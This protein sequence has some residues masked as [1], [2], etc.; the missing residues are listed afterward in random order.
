MVIACIAI[1]RTASAQIPVIEP[2]DSLGPGFVWFWS[3]IQDG[4]IVSRSESAGLRVIERT[5]SDNWVQTASLGT[6]EETGVVRAAVYGNT[7]IAMSVG[8]PEGCNLYVFARRQGAWQQVQKLPF[9]GLELA[10]GARLAALASSQSR[11][12]HV[13]RKQSDGTLE[14]EANLT[15]EEFGIEPPVAIAH[16]T[17]LV[18]TP[19]AND[20][21][22]AVQVFEEVG[23]DWVRRTTLTPSDPDAQSFGSRIQTLGNIA[24]IQAG[25]GDAF[26]FERVGR[27]WHEQTHLSGGGLFFLVDR[28]RVV[29]QLTSNGNVTRYLARLGGAEG[30]TPIAQL[31]DVLDRASLADG[32]TIDATRGFVLSFEEGSRAFVYDVRGW[33]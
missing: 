27:N 33:Q 1:A 32:I 2:S 18:G 20:G 11:V 6:D 9:C 13:F 12:V 23:G 8:P 28:H 16:D 24:L 3:D 31:G 19:R 21:R 25:F 4:T 17:V 29:V 22:G 10:L 15:G 5:S 26:I 14:L 30:W 7:A